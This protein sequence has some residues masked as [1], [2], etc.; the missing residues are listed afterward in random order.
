MAKIDNLT[1]KSDVFDNLLVMADGRK[2]TLSKSGSDYK[3]LSAIKTAFML[4]FSIK[5]VYLKTNF[6]QQFFSE[7][8]SFSNQLRFYQFS[9]QC[10]FS[11][12]SSSFFKANS[13]ISKFEEV[14]ND[15][16][17]SVDSCES[18]LEKLPVFCSKILRETLKKEKKLI[19][20]EKEEYLNGLQKREEEIIDKLQKLGPEF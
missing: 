1:I 20:Y 4:N 9:S 14:N 7:S 6:L 10:Y 13:A 11:F 15:L 16:A 5:D 2:V 17:F 19:N 3:I 8:N 18:G 12:Y